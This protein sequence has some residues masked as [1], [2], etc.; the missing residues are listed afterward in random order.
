MSLNNTE[1]T[2]QQCSVF[3]NDLTSPPVGLWLQGRHAER[4]LDVARM[5]MLG[6][7][8]DRDA[9]MWIG[10]LGRDLGRDAGAWLG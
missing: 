5:G 9:L 1:M 7:S 6:Y 10:M 4:V 2:R 8:Q 3:T